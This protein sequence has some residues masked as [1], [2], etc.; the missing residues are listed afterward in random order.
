[1]S[2]KP[3]DLYRDL[4]ANPAPVRARM[5][6][7]L[8]DMILLVLVGGVAF[9]GFGLTLVMGEPAV[10][11]DPEGTSGA[12]PIARGL[13]GMHIAILALPVFL[14]WLWN[15]VVRVSQGGASFGM[16]LLGIRL[17]SVRTGTS[18]TADQAVIRSLVGLSLTLPAL[19]GMMTIFGNR[20]RRGLHDLASG[21]VL[22]APPE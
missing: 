9:L 21:V 1:M 14:V 5:G 7:A 4:G 16:G 6:A 15:R 13:D 20:Q 10:A 18:P 22:I 8:V 2:Q 11:V 3:Y 19:L 12:G 17:V